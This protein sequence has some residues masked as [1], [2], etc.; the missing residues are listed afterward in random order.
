M[1]S[2][3][4][5]DSQDTKLRILAAATHL[6]SKHGFNGIGL[7]DI[8][9][10]AGVPKGSFYH[11]FASK[12]QLGVEL[13]RS[14][15]KTVLDEQKGWLGRSEMMPN[16]I[17]RLAA[18]IE[19]GLLDLLK[20][21]DTPA[22][23]MLK[24]GGEISSTSEAMR[25]EVAAFF[26]SAIR[27]YTDLIAEGQAAGQIRKDVPAAELASVVCDVWSGAYMRALVVRTAQALR[28]AVGHLKAYLAP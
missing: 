11:W 21:K 14:V 5:N 23:M 12:E 19:F 9:K 7:S 18:A 17:D 16:A 27:L 2:T 6:V 13:L 15:G 25:L 20:H 8:L 10:E 28:T 4:T 26:Q 24:L 22:G 1:S 3:T